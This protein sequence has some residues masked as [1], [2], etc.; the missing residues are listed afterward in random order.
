M[1]FLRHERTHGAHASRGGT[2][3]RSGRDACAGAGRAPLGR[4]V[5][6]RRRRVDGAAA[7][8]RSARRPGA[9]RTHR[10]HRAR[11]FRAGAAAG[12]HRRRSR[13]IPDAGARG[14]ARASPF[15]S[16]RIG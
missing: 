9:G 3:R 16:A 2:S 15:A 1:A 14:D 5:P 7:G 13:P 4:A 8:R 12:A 10:P 6:R 11:R